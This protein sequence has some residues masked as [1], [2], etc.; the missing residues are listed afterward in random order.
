[1][2][3]RLVA[4]S[5]LVPVLLLSACGESRQPPWKAAQPKAP[6]AAETRYLPAPAVAEAVPAEGG[7]RLSG[8]AAPGAKVMLGTPTGETLSAV[9]DGE[10][11][12]TVLAPTPGEVVLYGL[13]M[14]DGQ[15]KVNAEGYLL[16]TPDGRAAEL[17]SGGGARVL[18][19]GSRPPRILAIDFDRDGGAVVSGIGTPRADLGLRIDRNAGGT[20]MVS[21]E[22]RFSIVLVRP[23]PQ[24]EHEFEVSG[25]GGEDSVTVGIRRPDPLGEA[26]YRATPVGGGWRIDWRTPGG[27]VQTTLLTARRG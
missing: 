22:G 1:M 24:G 26:V 5:G 27:G 12:W 23:L 20:A 18:A 2:S 16:L 19:A 11:R 13:F 6:P 9:A 25:E 15:R 10:G 7:V 17:R 3:F 14:L 4:L 21:E 8:Q